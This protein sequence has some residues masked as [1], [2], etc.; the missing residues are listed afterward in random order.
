MAI[1][2]LSAKD[3]IKDY[4]ITWKRLF[5]HY[6]EG[7]LSKRDTAAE[8]QAIYLISVQLRVPPKCSA[9]TYMIKS[10][11]TGFRAM[12]KP[13]LDLTLEHLTDAQQVEVIGHVRRI[14]T[15]LA[16]SSRLW[17]TNV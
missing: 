1:P 8:L 13:G 14:C 9:T 3:L 7:T 15:V 5:L 11:P 4:E 12:A 16:Y 17:R 10:M 2:R 6:Y